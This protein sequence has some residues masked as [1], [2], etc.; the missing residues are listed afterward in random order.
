VPRVEGVARLHALL[1]RI[2]EVTGRLEGTDDADD[3]VA[4]LAELDTLAQELAAEVERQRRA[5][6]DE[7]E[8]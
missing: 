3:A 8:E 7:A 2:D 6:A 1:A 5:A 4:A